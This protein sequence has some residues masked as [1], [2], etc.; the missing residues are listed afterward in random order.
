MSQHL[1]PLVAS[2]WSRAWWGGGG[3]KGQVWTH[4]C[5]P[6]ASTFTRP[7]LPSQFHSCA[8]GR[9]VSHGPVVLLPDSP[10]LGLEVWASWLRA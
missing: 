6:V 1:S 3:A 5:A 2:S 10:G 4:H 9:C 7:S 8:T